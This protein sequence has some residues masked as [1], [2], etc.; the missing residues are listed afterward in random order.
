MSCTAVT[1]CFEAKKNP[2]LQLTFHSSVMSI[3][4]PLF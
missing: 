2:S 4:Y 3:S 1:K